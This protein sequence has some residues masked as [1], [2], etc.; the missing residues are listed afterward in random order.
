M[1]GTVAGW[2]AFGPRV[3]MERLQ[4]SRTIQRVGYLPVWS[5]V[6][7]VVG[8]GFRRRG[9]AHAL[10]DGVVRYARDH[11]VTTLEAYPVDTS[12]GRMSP[13]LAFVGTTRM[14]EAAGFHCVEPTQAHSARLVRWLM[15]RE[16]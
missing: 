11:G 4:R 8:A 5:I 7:F 14:F 12:G 10:P 2:C 9:V 1:G 13:T 3:E 16:L 6:C 15:R